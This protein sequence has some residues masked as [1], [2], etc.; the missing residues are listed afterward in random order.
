MECGYVSV[1]FLVHYCVDM[2]SVLDYTLQGVRGSILVR[3]RWPLSAGSLSLNG[4]LS[5]TGNQPRRRK[6]LATLLHYAIGLVVCLLD[7]VFFFRYDT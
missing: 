3:S 5:M 2:R 7:L 1:N 4:Y 6:E